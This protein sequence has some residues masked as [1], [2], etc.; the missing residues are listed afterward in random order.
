MQ[1]QREITANAL[2]FLTDDAVV[3]EL[4]DEKKKKPEQN[5]RVTL[6]L[7]RGIWSIQTIILIALLTS[8]VIVAAVIWSV[9]YTQSQKGVR[10]V[11]VIARRYALV[12]LIQ[13]LKDSN[14][15]HTLHEAYDQMYW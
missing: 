13:Q 10:S 7:L 5:K 15:P 2:S 6:R 11:S 14:G 8:V 3:V 12:S 1:Q 4:E 9:N